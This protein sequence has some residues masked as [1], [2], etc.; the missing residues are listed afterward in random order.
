MDA[1][2]VAITPLFVIAQKFKDEFM[3]TL[4]SKQLRSEMAVLENLIKRYGGDMNLW[5]AH[6]NVAVEL[7]YLRDISP[8]RRRGN[9]DSEQEDLSWME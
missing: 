6:D 2:S 4:A 9:D 3:I 5:G 1:V 8:K 7:D